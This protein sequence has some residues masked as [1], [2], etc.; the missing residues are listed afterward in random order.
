MNEHEIA[1][2]LEAA[3]GSVVRGQSDVVRKVLACLVSGGHILLEDY[4]G[5]GK[6]TLAKAISKAIDGALT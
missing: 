1:T 6:T 5:T 4:P 3:V 2:K